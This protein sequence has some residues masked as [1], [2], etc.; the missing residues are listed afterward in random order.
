MKTGGGMRRSLGDRRRRWQ[1][2]ARGIGRSYGILRSL[3]SELI[4][5]KHPAADL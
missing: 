4:L 5:F 3:P 1:P 2:I